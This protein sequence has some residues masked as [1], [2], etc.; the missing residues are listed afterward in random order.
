M[1]YTFN[2]LDRPW[3]PCVCADGK[4][5]L[6][7]LQ[8]TLQQAHRLHGI[9]GDSP[10]ETA[11]LYRLLLAVL[12]SSLRGPAKRSEWATLWKNGQWNSEPFS[13]YLSKWHDRFDLFHPQR[14]FYQ[15]HSDKAKPK[16]VTSLVMD[17]AAGNQATLFDHHTEER[18]V[19]L[20]AAKA[21]RS[22][23]VAHTFG[24]GGLV[25]PGVSFTDAPWGRGMILL[26][27]GNN[28][29]ETL[30]LN[31]LL[32]PNTSKNCLESTEADKPSW[33]QE[34]PYSPNR[35]KPLGYLDYLT[36][37]NRRIFLIPEGNIEDPQISMMTIFIGLRQD[38]TLQ[39]PMKSYK[40]GKDGYLVN[41]FNEGRA[42]WRDSATLFGLYRSEK[43]HP[44]QTFY[45]L[46]DLAAN[47]LI[48]EKERYRFMALGMANDQAKVEFFQQEHFPLPLAYLEND[49]LVGQLS[50]SLGYADKVRFEI[51]RAVQWLALLIISPK[52]VDKKWPEVDRISKD[53]AEK[54]FY[55]WNV[56]AYFWQNLEIPFMELLENLPKQPQVLEDWMGLLQKTAKDSLEKAVTLAG[57]DP[58]VL[59]S[60]VKAR[61]ILAYSLK[62]L[63]NPIL[64]E[65]PL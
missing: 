53:Q 48:T 41:R 60:A 36:W 33:E 51:K 57:T 21:A 5:E 11:A 34:D 20:S 65:K 26:V 52:A 4:V 1:T 43:G 3:I 23:I 50:D 18:G 37:Q 8:D 28:L 64:E 42:L 14:P 56:E 24:L 39:D 9:Q 29:F 31:L 15:S 38:A 61:Q 59:K 35:I 32:Y 6:F 47:D 40:M 44:P 2:L 12:H 19:V 58:A 54:M 27:E 46:A 17:M 10:L 45:W 63:F 22:L 25:M 30:C 49:T 62:E 13:S 16:S 55:H 7:S